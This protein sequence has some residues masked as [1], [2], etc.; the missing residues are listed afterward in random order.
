MKT[1]KTVYT[2]KWVLTA[3]FTALVT[4]ATMIIKIPTVGTGG[5]IHFGDAFVILSGIILGPVY[6]ALA[7]G[8]GSALSDLIGGYMVYVP[9]TFVIKSLVGLVS[10]IIYN[11]F[12]INKTNS[13][14]RCIIC[15]IFATIIVAGGYL[16]Y[17]LFFYGNA[18]FSSVPQNIIQGLSG[19][20]ISVILLPALRKAIIFNED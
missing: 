11:K 14:V 12:M 1:N 15:G 16:L 2:K 7:G 17:E 10:G 8:L 13:F 6:G 3:L 19:L 18:A 20:V 5:Y 9:A 4:V